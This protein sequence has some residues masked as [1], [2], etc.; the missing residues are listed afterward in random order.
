MILK[1]FKKIEYED[2]AQ[3]ILRVMVILVG[4]FYLS[5]TLE[6]TDSASNGTDNLVMF[7]ISKTD[8][9]PNL[10]MKN[11]QSWYLVEAVMFPIN[12]AAQLNILLKL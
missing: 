6:M 12:C 5:Q 7:S 8:E 11:V 2:V 9:K 3:R 4:V 10:L 1:F